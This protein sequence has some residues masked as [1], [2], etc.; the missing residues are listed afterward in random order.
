VGRLLFKLVS[1]VHSAL[2]RGS[3]GRIA[4]RVGKLDVLL[5]TTTG[6]KTGKPRTVPLLY[7][8]AGNGY[9][10]V[11]SKGGAPEDPAW[12]L[13]LRATPAARVDLG[14]KQVTVKA[15]EAEGEEYDR[16]WTQMAQG[17]TGYGGYK[18][19]T[20]RRIPVFVLDP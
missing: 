11:G 12:A 15:R 7:T 19:K 14:G 3:R 16:L 2:Y 5:L 20:T 1:G 10:V 18:E 9:A 13:N 4:G 6:R 17:Y 8:P